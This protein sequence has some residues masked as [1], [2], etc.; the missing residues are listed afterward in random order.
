M[1]ITFLGTADGI[2]R[3]HH[4]CTATAVE[5]G[6]DVYLIDGGAPVV[7]TL[8][9]AGIDPN[10]I[11]A[12]FNTHPHAD[13]V[14]GITSLLTLSTWWYKEMSFDIYWAMKKTGEVLVDYV[15]AFVDF[16]HDRIAMKEIPGAG[17]FYDDGVLKV[18]AFPTLHCEPKPSY[19]FLL[20]AEGK[21]VFFSGDVSYALYRNDFPTYV[22]EEPTDLFIC[23]MA[24]IGEEEVLPYLEQCRAG[25]VIFNHYQ[26]KKEEH[27]E[28]L[29]APGRFP[30]PVAMAHD[31]ESVTV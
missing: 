15:S 23:E 12:I 16:P 21:R 8:L 14:D 10:R 11:K 7:D 20:E 27:I 19:A 30:F 28:R 5:I 24:H 25:R 29:S 1:K 4:A 17:T 26:Q 9:S 31:G 22:C 18:T 13:H 3:P 2:P 6:E